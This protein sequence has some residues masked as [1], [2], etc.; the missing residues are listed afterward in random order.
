MT[1]MMSQ[2][3]AET[4]WLPRRR[5]TTTLQW[6]RAVYEHQTVMLCVNLKLR[7]LMSTCSGNMT[8]LAQY[9]CWP[10]FHLLQNRRTK[11]YINFFMQSNYYYY[12]YCNGAATTNSTRRPNFC[13][14]PW[15]RVHTD[16]K[17]LFL[18]LAKTN[19]QGF[20]G[21]NF[22]KDFPG[23]IPFSHMGCMRSNKV[24]LNSKSVTSV[25]AS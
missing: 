20:P 5:P 4:D 21:L 15:S 11:S 16:I 6:W 23:Y 7:D 14:W 2:W 13:H 9:Q 17:I 12:Y 1:M 3:R 10:H 24:Q 8:F 19:F 22:F 25:S 18:G